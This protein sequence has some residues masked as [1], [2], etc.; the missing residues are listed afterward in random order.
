MNRNDVTEKIYVSQAHPTGR[1]TFVGPEG[2]VQTVTG[3]VLNDSVK[4]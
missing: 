4:D 1:I 3:Y 2:D